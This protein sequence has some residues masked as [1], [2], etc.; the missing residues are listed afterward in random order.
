M[1]QIENVN[2]TVLLDIAIGVQDSHPKGSPGSVGS[3]GT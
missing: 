2:D 3:E 1:E